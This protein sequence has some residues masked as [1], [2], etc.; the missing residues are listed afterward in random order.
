MDL[1]KIG[2][3]LNEISEVSARYSDYREVVPSKIDYHEPENEMQEKVAKKCRAGAGPLIATV[4]AVFLAAGIFMA[5]K[6]GPLVFGIIIS[7][8]GAGILVF[9]G[10]TLLSRPMVAECRAVWKQVRYTSKSSGGRSKTY[11]VTVVI[12]HPE[13]LLCK[14][15][16]TTKADYDRIE[17]G[18][19]VLLVKT[20]PIYSV[21]L[22]D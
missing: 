16:Q 20:G 11:H 10:M 22:E 8:L 5:V 9:A 15:V 3:M 13:K 6:S 17:E 7:L 14:L 4:G 2:M 12:E 1:G 21:R 19:E 18:T